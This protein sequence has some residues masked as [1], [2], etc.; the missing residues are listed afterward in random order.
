MIDINEMGEV[1]ADHENRISFLENCLPPIEAVATIEA[2]DK[3]GA[4]EGVPELK[5]LQNQRDVIQQ[6]QSEVRGWRTKHAD[7]LKEIDI[8]KAKVDRSNKKYTY[9]D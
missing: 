6:L 8:L 7:T 3:G 4:L 2:D 5:W 1:L 9:T